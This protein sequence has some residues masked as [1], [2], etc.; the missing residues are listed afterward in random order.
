MNTNTVQITLQFKDD[1]SIVVDQAKKK[2]DDL[3]KSVKGSTGGLS[4]WSE[5]WGL[6]TAKIFAVTAA[7]YGAKRLIYDTAVQIASATNAIERQAT[8]LGINTDELQKWQYAAKMSDVNAQELAIGIKFLSRNME[9]ASSGAGESSKYFSAMGISVKDAHGNLRPLNDVMGDVMDKFASWEDGPRKIAIALQIFGRS[10][11]NL[12]PLLN[13]GRIGFDELAEEAR[14]FGI[15]LSP[16]LIR[17]GSEAE[18]AF[19]KLDSQINSMKLSLAPS[20]LAFSSFL[21]SMLKDITAFNANPE[22]KKWFTPI[23][24]GSTPA[25]KRLLGRLF[26][27]YFKMPEAPEDMGA[28]GYLGG[29]QTGK[30]PIVEDTAKKLKE[31][32][33]SQRPYYESLSK[34]A[35]QMDRGAYGG[36]EEGAFWKQLERQKEIEENLYRIEMERAEQLANDMFPSEE[37]VLQVTEKMT[38]IGEKLRLQL[39]ETQGVVKDFGWED[40]AAGADAANESTRKLNEMIIQNTKSAEKLFERN[41]FTEGLVIGL[42]DTWSSTFSSMRRSQESFSEWFKGA[43]LDMA[44]YAI[45]QIQKMAMNY[46][47]LGSISGKTGG[48]SFFGKSSGGYGGLIGGLLGALKLQEGGQFWVNRPTPLLVGEGGGREFVS[49][50]P[51]NKMGQGG[52]T[53][54]YN[55]NNYL[56]QTVDQEGVDKLLRRSGATILKIATDDIRSFGPLRNA[57]KRA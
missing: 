47:L 27:Y 53:I 8:V 29:P 39:V 54:I 28:R 56:V 11:E 43:W 52:Q 17:K 24:P 5:D 49:V 34:Q 35:E 12:I 37:K 4:G 41:K 21:T 30:P 44:D 57:V 38:E 46:A 25:G 48:T 33:D 50:T 19:K 14:K 31:Y 22:V 26:P 55:T 23:E 42:V 1:G 2:I 36:M 7:L 6:A 13:K 3:D 10:G 32:Y 16:D 51:E 18:T 20:A 45:G 9:D 40:Y 15:I